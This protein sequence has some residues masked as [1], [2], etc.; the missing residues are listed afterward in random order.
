MYGRIR[1]IDVKLY[2][3]RKIIEDGYIVIEYVL[4]A[5]NMADLFIKGL[6]KV[7]LEEYNRV[8]GLLFIFY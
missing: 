6:F 7:K 8:L 1:Y 4:I 3:I 2:F 5:E